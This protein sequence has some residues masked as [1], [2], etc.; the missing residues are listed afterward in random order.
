MHGTAQRFTPATLHGLTALLDHATETLQ[1]QPRDS[2]GNLKRSAGSL[3]PSPLQSEQTGLLFTG[4]PHETVP[5]RLLLDNRLTPLERNAWQVFRLLLN[6]DG[7]TSFPTYEQLRPYLAAS[8]FKLASRE[9]VA[10]VLT[11]LRLTRWLSLAGRV[12]DEATGQ[13]KGNIYLLHDE[14]ISI[15]EALLLDGSYLELLGNA[16]EHANKSIREVA[17][18]TLEEFQRDPDV[19]DFKILTRLDILQ[20]RLGRQKWAKPEDGPKPGPG[21]GPASESELSAQ[22]S[23][24]SKKQPVRNR[25]APRSESEPIGKPGLC[26]LVRNPN[27]SSTSTNTDVFKDLVPRASEPPG[28]QV[29]AYPPAFLALTF[30]QRQKLQTAL[31]LIAPE[32]QSQVLEQW[33][34]RCDRQ[35]MRNP[36]GYLFGMIDRA[37]N[38]E[39]NVFGQGQGGGRVSG[40]N[41]VP[42][43]AEVQCS[44]APCQAKQ[45][46]SKEAQ[47]LARSAMDGMMRIMAGG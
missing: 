20:R 2:P 16:Q 47:A 12:R 36:A 9:T 13:V 37:R 29:T 28:D 38:G 19:R 18:F 40:F 6:D 23:E 15:S 3:Q 30:D 31:S 26:G 33:A 21:P 44:P 11:T 45:P 25:A 34:Q 35:V 5:R 24:L 7:L 39:F 10:K 41:Q 17:A 22:H 32:L 46:P 43:E 14:P 27:S 8:P 42:L 1:Q 4:N